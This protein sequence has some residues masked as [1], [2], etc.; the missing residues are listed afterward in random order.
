MDKSNK[1]VTFINRDNVDITFTVIDEYN[2]LVKRMYN[3]LNLECD[4]LVGYMDQKKCEII[5]QGLYQ[6]MKYYVVEDSRYN[7]YLV[8]DSN[9]D[10]V[11]SLTI[12][13]NQFNILQKLQKFCSECT[14]GYMGNDFI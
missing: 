9:G 2:D 5:S 6:I 10:P 11:I 1:V 3:F 12:S 4:S 14:K 13:E 7:L 8:L